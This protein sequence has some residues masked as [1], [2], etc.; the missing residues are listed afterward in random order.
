MLADTVT[1]LPVCTSP[2]AI[3]AQAW[4]TI[5][6]LGFLC[7]IVFLGLQSPLSLSAWQA[8]SGR[9]LRPLPPSPLSPQPTI[10]WLLPI[11]PVHSCFLETPQ[12]T[13]LAFELLF[14]GSLLEECKVGHKANSWPVLQLPL[15]FSSYSGVMKLSYSFLIP[16]LT[17]ESPFSK[18]A[19]GFT[20]GIANSSFRFELA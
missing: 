6:D 16:T 14:Q 7:L 20:H 5:S 2:S 13:R 9:K 18:N 15:Y 12:S 17:R 3:S 11:A 1:T 19:Q 8:G 4:L 10:Y